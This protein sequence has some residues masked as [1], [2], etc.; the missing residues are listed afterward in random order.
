LSFLKFVLGIFSNKLSCQ[1]PG[2]SSL[3]NYVGGGDQWIHCLSYRGWAMLLS[4]SLFPLLLRW[5]EAR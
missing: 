4:L 2:S 3:V 5:E 1:I